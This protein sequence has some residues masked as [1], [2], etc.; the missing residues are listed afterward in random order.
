[1]KTNVVLQPLACWPIYEE[2]IHDTAF[3]IE[4]AIAEI[5]SLFENGAGFDDGACRRNNLAVFPRLPVHQWVLS[6][7]KRLRY[8]LR[9]DRRPVT[10]VLTIFLRV[11]EGCCASGHP[12]AQPVRDWGQ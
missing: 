11:V 3:S 10:A 6:L 1:M 8:F 5:K 7:P 9:Q 2:V 12:V 4:V